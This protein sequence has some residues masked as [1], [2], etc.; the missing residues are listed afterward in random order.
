MPTNSSKPSE[1]GIPPVSALEAALS[2]LNQEGGSNQM[3]CV[4]LKALLEAS[5]TA[6]QRGEPMPSKSA[7]DLLA[8]WHGHRGAET[9]TRLTQSS[10]ENGWNSRHEGLAQML[11][12]RG[13]PWQVSLTTTPGGGRGNPTTYAF[14]VEPDAYAGTAEPEV[15]GGATAPGCVRYRIDP[16]KS[17]AW[18]R[19]LLGNKPFSLLSWRGYALLGFGALD[20]LGVIALWTWL[21]LSWL[22]PRPVTTADLA[23]LLVVIF[24]TAAIWWQSRPLMRLASQRVVP[25]SEIFVAFS[26]MYAQFRSMREGGAKIKGRT[27]S[28]V[29]H[30]AVCPVC[31][32]EVD[33]EGGGRAFPDRLVGRCGDSPQE[34]VYS[35]DPITLIGKPLR[36]T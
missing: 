11:R 32:G 24:F 33:L 7:A 6:C 15:T 13:I 12:D 10:V 30:W 35:F 9:S 23:M 28:I 29:R 19:L 5:I 4:A 27:F 34:H 25:A 17:A 1:T 31:A 22:R 16:V 21:I 26:T 2:W 8:V 3:V 14:A 18:F 20:I 36:N